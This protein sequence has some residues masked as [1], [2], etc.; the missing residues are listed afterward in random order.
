MSILKEIPELV[1]AGVISQDT[2]DKIRDYYRKKEGKSQNRLIVVFGILGAILVGL[3][4][5]LIIAHNWDELPR[6]TKTFLAFLPLIAGQALCG[7]TLVRKQESIAWRES[8]S[9]ILFFAV[10]AAISLVSQI[11]N[12]PG[13]LSSFLLIWMLLCLPLIYLMKSSVTSLLYLIGITC[14]ACETGYWSHPSDMP[15]TFWLLLIA[16]LP[17]YY[18]LFTKKPE[19]NFMLFHNW[20]IP[21]S[22]TIALGTVANQMEELMFIAYFSLF[23]LFYLLGNPGFFKSQ[24]PGNISYLILGSL[25]TI[26]LLLMLSFD[27]F[28]QNLRGQHFL[29]SNLIISP[30]FIA[31]AFLTVCASA[32][33]FINRKNRPWRGIKPMETVFVLFI[34]IFLIGL[35]SPAAAWIINIIVLVIG[36]LTIIDGARRDQ[37]WLLNYGLLII[38]ALV[39]CRFFDTDLSF[40]IR[41]ILFVSVG[42]GFFVTNYKMLERRKTNE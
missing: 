2:A 39:I 16:A 18:L 12:I 31:V 36:I 6:M 38:T 10:G 34:I 37:L 26:I 21:L 35:Y 27:W 7:F 22:V 40:V 19:S 17:H 11:Y 9:I 13:N 5:I 24:K 33:F 32:L 29:F 3:G 20:L 15:Y 23:G 1:N 30:E 41:G 14:Y 42:I 4:I 25:G 28:W 8:C